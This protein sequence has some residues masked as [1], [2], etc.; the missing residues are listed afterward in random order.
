MPSGTNTIKFIAKTAVPYGRTVTYGNMVCDIRPQKKETHRVRLTVGGDK[1]EYPGDV[2]T[3]TSDLTTAK[4]LINS[5]L[6]T[7]KAKGLCI[8]VKDFYLNTDMDRCEYM[9]IKVEIIPQE[10]MEQYELEKLACGGWVYIEIQ[11]G[12]YGLPQAGKL[13]NDKLKA[14]LALFGYHPTK[15][16]PG[17]WR[18]ESRDITFALTVDDFFIKYTDARDANHLL[19]TLKQQYTISEDWDATL[20]YGV[21]LNWD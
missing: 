13:A 19:D 12:M 18:H 3:P 11:K 20:Y 4:C 17:L 9:R 7:S 6:S 15:H 14:Y 1:V 10:I 21:T 2:S 16:T 5:I 8:D